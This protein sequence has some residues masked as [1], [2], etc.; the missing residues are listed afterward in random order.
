MKTQTIIGLVLLLASVT[1]MFPTAHETAAYAPWSNA[2]VDQS[3]KCPEKIIVGVVDVP[4]GWTD[5]NRRVI[6]F[7][8]LK[9]TN[10]AEGARITCDYDKG[11]YAV[12]RFVPGRACVRTWVTGPH[13]T[14]RT[15]P[16]K[17]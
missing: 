15:I 6:P 12:D 7:E 10:T 3:E 11:R 13:V 9:V 5:Y 4:H 8:N 17:K 14:C 2:F 1:T 16:T